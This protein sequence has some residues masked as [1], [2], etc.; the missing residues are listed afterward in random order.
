[1]VDRLCLVYPK[2]SCY[3]VMCRSI[4]LLTENTVQQVSSTWSH[5]HKQWYVI[6]L[7]EPPLKLGHGWIITTHI[8]SWVDVLS[9]PGSEVKGTPL[10][11]VDWTT[12]WLK[13]CTHETKS[14]YENSSWSDFTSLIFELLND[15][16][17][18]WRSFFHRLS[19]ARNI[20][21]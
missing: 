12:M 16:V 18:L 20:L 9:M 5:L 21:M 7:A 13:V 3:H 17:E 11:S 6:K 10:A 1:M 8:K 15:G 19:S 4:F 2:A 14:K